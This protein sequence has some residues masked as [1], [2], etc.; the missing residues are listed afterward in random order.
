MPY[1]YYVDPTFLILIPA[2]ILSFIAQMMVNSAFNK[3]KRVRSLNGY[4]GEQVARMMLNEAGLQ[5]ISIERCERSLGDHYDPRSGVIRLSPEVY[6]GS[7]IAA[8]GIAAHEVGHAIQY[9]QE[10]SPLIIR[11][12]IVPAVNFSSSFS[13]VL[14]FAGILFSFK[15]LVTIGIFL[16]S[17]TVIFQLITLPVEFNASSRALGILNSRGILYGDEVDGAKK[18]LRAAAL[19]YVAAALMAVLQLVRLILISRRDD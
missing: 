1:G 2:V 13:W 6:N 12:A 18:V 8:A 7:T 17:A 4:T 10:Y 3:Y 19:T 16:F 15:P 11:N 14:F 9:Q 5:G